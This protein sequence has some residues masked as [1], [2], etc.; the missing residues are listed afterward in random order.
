MIQLKLGGGNMSDLD[1]L[2]RLIESK[3]SEM[4]ELQR[5][6]CALPA[7]APESGGDGEWKKALMLKEYLKEMGFKEILEYDA[8]DRRVTERKRPNLII[9][10]A[11]KTEKKALWIMTHL[12]VVPPGENKH[13]KHDPYQLQV[14]NGKLF[15]RGTE[16]NHQGLV[17]SIFALWALKQAGIIPPLTVK[18][19]F[20]ADEETG[21]GYGIK[22]LLKNKGRLFGLK[23]CVLVPDAG[24]KDGS[25]IEIAEKNVLWLKFRVLGVQCHASLPHLGRN[26]FVAGSELVLKLS[27][28]NQFYTEKDAIF[29]PPVSTFSPTKKEANVPN[30]NTIPG[31]DVFYLDCRLLPLLT[32]NKA[33]NKI[34]TLISE[35]EK[36][37][38]VKIDMQIIQKESSPPT[39]DNIPLISVLK[40]AIRTVYGVKGKAVGIGG[41]TVGA[42]LRKKGIN[43]VVWAKLD[44]TAHMPNEYC[45]VKNMIGDAK[46]MAQAM[47]S[48]SAE[49]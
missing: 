10:L 25:M 48:L 6:L 28:L 24:A 29:R 5:R 16:D 31:E 47:L 38:M 33:I 14:K 41:G 3:K 36:K 35:V 49:T 15:G 40:K 39:P 32:I 30:I 13:W 46:V 9:S 27:A 34:K 7:I 26:A 11:G 45:L 18:L 19:L 4:I 17:S 20:I 37:Y 12:D 42:H 21:S 8:P 2:F 1:H 22:Y 44:S 43:T 23:D